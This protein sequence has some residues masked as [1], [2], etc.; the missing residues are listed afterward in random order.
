MKPV[1]EW[2]RLGVHLEIPETDLLT[3]R[4]DH[5]DQTE[6][7]RLEMLIK[8]GEL[9]KRTWSK[10]VKALVSI[11]RKVLA[12]KIAKK[13]GMCEL[14]QTISFF[15]TIMYFIYT[16]IGL[17]LPRVEEIRDVRL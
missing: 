4:K 17:P 16:I 9:E 14:I 1:V 2:F 10:L 7:C 11:D 6:E 5:R 8:W 15:V 13:Y 12:N 3:I